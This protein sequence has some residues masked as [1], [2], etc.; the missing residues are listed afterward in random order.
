[1]HMRASNTLIQTMVRTHVVA[2]FSVPV[3]YKLST[4]VHHIGAV[5]ERDK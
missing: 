3:F 5:T 4:A 1:M 2:S